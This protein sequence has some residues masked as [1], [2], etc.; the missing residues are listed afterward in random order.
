MTEGRHHR[1]RCMHLARQLG[2][3][4]RLAAAQAPRGLV[5]YPREDEVLRR[6]L[7]ERSQGVHDPGFQGVRQPVGALCVHSNFNLLVELP[8]EM[9]ESI[10]PAGGEV[11]T[12]S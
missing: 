9:L 6:A 4:A 10:A 11:E 8:E 1:T 12:K 2:C 3:E 5:N 7:G